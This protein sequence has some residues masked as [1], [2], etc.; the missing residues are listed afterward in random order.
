MLSHNKIMGFIPSSNLD[1]SR[2]FYEGVLGM[3]VLYQDNFAV[4][5]DAGGI[6]VRLTNVGQFTPQKFTVFGWEVPDIDKSVADLKKIGINFQ[7]FGMP[8]QNAEG[9]WTSP[10]G[11]RVAWF[12][13]PDG[14]NLSVT[15]FAAAQARA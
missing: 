11:A 1:R 10:S 13:D 5:L 12:Q 14:N 2:A 15:Q 7:H 4:A 9:I 8:D 3:R 6:M